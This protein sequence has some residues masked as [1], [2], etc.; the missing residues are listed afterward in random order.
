MWLEN[1]RE[2]KAKKGLTNKQIAEKERLTE[3][4]VSRIFSGETDCPSADILYK[5]ARALGG[6][7]DAIL[8]DTGAVVGGPDLA[9]LQ[10]EVD[11]LNGEMTQLTSE[12]TL[13][14][15]ELA[16]L[17]DKANTLSAENEVLRLKLEHKDE[18]LALHNYYMKMKSNE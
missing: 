1:L 8:A 5:I 11:R 12:L 3:R 7:L 18:L 2:L 4:T 9:E 14:N 16:V 17:R 10:A 15:A 13:A 6:S